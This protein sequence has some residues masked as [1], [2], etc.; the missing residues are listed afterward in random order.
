MANDLNKPAC[1]T[2]GG[3]GWL[4]G[5][6]FYEPGEGGEKCPDCALTAPV[7]TKQAQAVASVVGKLMDMR[8]SM[9]AQSQ[10]ERA[11]VLDESIVALQALAASPEAAPAAME[12]DKDAKTW[13]A[14]VAGIVETYLNGSPSPEVR[15]KAIAGIIARRLWAL[16]SAATPAAPSGVM[17][18]LNP[19]TGDCVSVKCKADWASAYGENAGNV[20]SVPLIAALAQPA[21]VQPNE[22]TLTTTIAD[23]AQLTGRKMLDLMTEAARCGITV[24]ANQPFDAL[25]LLCMLAAP[26]QPKC[27]A[28]NGHGLV[29]G[30][31][32]GG[33]GYDS[34]DCPECKGDGVAPVQQD[35]PAPSGHDPLRELH[36]LLYMAQRIE[37]EQRDKAIGR[38]RVI[39]HHL[40]DSAQSCLT[41]EHL[42]GAAISG[43]KPAEGDKV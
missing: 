34:Q 9:R 20:Y 8:F 37:G 29:G 12:A 11:A 32:S 17:A 26:V 24:T 27:R 21:P 7:A 31:L 14:Y 10:W 38:A 23:L 18:W 15:E 30:L 33:G 40:R 41:P 5:P 1:M 2:C 43:Q 36:D 19:E 22:L 13:T 16:P 35:A 42:K 28:C 6:S 4:G 25:P 3:S 39:V